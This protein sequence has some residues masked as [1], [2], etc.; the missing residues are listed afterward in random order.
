MGAVLP[1]VDQGRAPMAPMFVAPPEFPRV[2]LSAACSYNVGAPPGMSLTGALGG[3]NTGAHNGTHGKMRYHTNKQAWLRVAE[4]GNMREHTLHLTN[5]QR[6]NIQ[7]WQP[8]P[9]PMSG[10]SEV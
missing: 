5:M 7:A 9:P 6:T 4:H 1:A 8:R 10:V 2:F 3:S